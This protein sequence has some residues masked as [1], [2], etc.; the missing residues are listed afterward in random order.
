MR[1]TFPRL[2]LVETS[3]SRG[4]GLVLGGKGRGGVR[5]HVS[6]DS[7]EGFNVTFHSSYIYITSKRKHRETL[8]GFLDYIEIGG[9]VGEY[10]T[11][12]SHLS[13]LL[14]LPLP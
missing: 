11:L 3:L 7:G 5:R 12:R 6:W 8:Q 13:F 1:A 10:P 4:L 2:F 9:N 14:P